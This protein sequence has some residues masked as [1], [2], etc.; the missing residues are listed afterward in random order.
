M[1]S[2]LK[3]IRRNL[4]RIPACTFLI[5]LCGTSHHRGLAAPSTISLREFVMHESSNGIFYGKVDLRIGEVLEILF[6]ALPLF[7]QCIL[8]IQ[9]SSHDPQCIHASLLKEGVAATLDAGFI[10][11][12]RQ[13][14][15][16]ALTAR[17]AWL[18]SPLRMGRTLRNRFRTS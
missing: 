15:K 18:R 6:D 4:R 9:D 8:R 2:S 11:L 12:S 7:R 16:D 17:V 5:H 13:Q 1:T 14:R 10:L 3:G